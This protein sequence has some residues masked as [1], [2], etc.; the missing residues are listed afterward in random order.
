MNYFMILSFILNPKEVL[1]LIF[2][3]RLR[4]LGVLKLYILNGCSLLYVNFTL[5]KLEKTEI[6]DQSKVDQLMPHGQL[7]RDSKLG[8]GKV[9]L[10][11]GTKSTG[12]LERKYLGRRIGRSES[13]FNHRGRGS[14]QPPKSMGSQGY[15]H[16]WSRQKHCSPKPVCR[17]SPSKRSY[18]INRL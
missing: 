13:H 9:K 11:E 14:Q 17:C 8:E 1:F 18:F 4:E 15:V 16:R 5:I 12:K 10:Y 6:G 2:Q 3:F 7:V